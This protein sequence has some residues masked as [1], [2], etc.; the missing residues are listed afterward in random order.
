MLEINFTIAFSWLDLHDNWNTTKNCSWKT[1]LYYLCLFNSVI[2]SCKQILCC[3]LFKKGLTEEPFP[4]RAD[5][6]REDSF[7]HI[8]HSSPYASD[9]MIHSVFAF[10]AGTAA[11]G[12]HTPIFSEFLPRATPQNFYDL[13]GAELQ[14]V[15]CLHP[16][17]IPGYDWLSPL[18]W[19]PL[20]N[21]FGICKN[22]VIKETWGC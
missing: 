1:S 10:D 9:F 4:G 21:S 18:L 22:I 15:F 19:P 6:A 8:R 11:P 16:S 3:A 17:S 14:S 7:S 20:G 5:S 12:F 13:E 2:V